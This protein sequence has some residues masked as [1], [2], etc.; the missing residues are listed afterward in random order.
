MTRRRGYEAKRDTII[1]AALR[2][3][4]DQGYDALTVEEVLSAAG[5]SKGTFYHYFPSKQA[6]VEASLLAVS[7]SIVSGATTAG[8]PDDDSPER[9]LEPFLALVQPPADTHAPVNRALAQVLLQTPSLETLRTRM[10]DL[11]AERLTPLVTE[12]L[13]LGARRGLFRIADPP[14]TAELLVSLTLSARARVLALIS[15]ADAARWADAYL[16]IVERTLGL[17]PDTLSRDDAAPSEGA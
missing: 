6:L 10:F 5:V 16:T 1:T 12:A 2:I 3:L 15:S 17:P 9:L 8:T 7:D 13:D 14:V 11:L 4:A